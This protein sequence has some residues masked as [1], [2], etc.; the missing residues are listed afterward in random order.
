MD[1][2]IRSLGLWLGLI[3]S[4]E[5]QLVSQ[6]PQATL[7]LSG[8]ELVYIVQNGQARQVSSG[9]F[10]SGSACSV[11]LGCT[12]AA[13]V[14]FNGAGTGLSVANSTTLHGGTF[15]GTYTGAPTF[16]N[17]SGNDLVLRGQLA[18]GSGVAANANTTIL[19]PN[20][21]N[22]LLSPQGTGFVSVTSM[23]K[24]YDAAIGF[25]SLTITAGALTPVFEVANNLTGTVTTSG[26][27]GWNEISVPADTMTANGSAAVMSDLFITHNF[28]GTNFQGSRAGLSIALIQNGAVAG[29]PGVFANVIDG[30]EMGITLNASFGGSGTTLATAAGAGTALN[31][32]T[33][34]AS[35][36]TNG[37]GG[38]GEE[39][40]ISGRTGSSFAIKQGLAIVLDN[41][42]T[43]QGALQD[44]A[45]VFSNQTAQGS[46][47]GW[48]A[49]ISVGSPTGYY[50]PATNGAF[51]VLTHNGAG[52]D[53]VTVNKGLSWANGTFT[54][55]AIETPGFTLDGSGN[56]SALSVGNGSTALQVA[57]AGSWSA[58]GATTVSLT[59]IAPSGAHATVQEWLTFKDASGTVRYIPAF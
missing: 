19:T 55:S 8:Q 50:G 20:G 36:F 37:L 56:V 52:G 57:G 6:M 4:A 54:T 16:N 12:Y 34:F 51:W 30:A 5:A 18:I 49:L 27:Q 10:P 13:R 58:N 25:N 2:V 3:G 43:V 9:N 15:T 46:G 17:T 31:P 22:I 26:V 41:Q 53:T 7:P 29:A 48:G 45:L 1:K 35:G 24:A 42:D 23:L 11:V 14:T 59:N 47:R 40:D 28:G 39:I 44:A 32:Y 21:S 38:S 33:T